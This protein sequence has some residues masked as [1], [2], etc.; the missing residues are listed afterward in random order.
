MA[1]LKGVPIGERGAPT[2]VFGTLAIDRRVLITSART[3]CLSNVAAISIGT[4]PVQTSPAGLIGAIVC[5]LAA[6]GAWY[7]LGTFFG[8]V[9]IAA[10]FVVL[11]LAAIGLLA[12]WFLTPRVT[13]RFLIITSNDGTRSLFAA[14]APELLEKVRRI[15]TDKINGQDDDATFTINFDKGTI[16]PPPPG[17]AVKAEQPAHGAGH[18]AAP[19]SGRGDSHDQSHG[20]PHPTHRDSG[21]EAHASPTGAL[22]AGG[23]GTSAGPSQSTHV[24]Y[25]SVLGQIEQM[26]RFYAQQPQARHVEER[27]SELELLMR[28]GTPTAEGRAR[29]RQLAADLGTILQSYPA[30]VQFFQGIIHLVGH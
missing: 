8:G 7:A 13:A 17:D 15:L 11:V 6:G 24:D 9:A 10:A 3:I 1:G 22:A 2:E 21:Y 14:H 16:D 27:L 4:F 5:A 12:K 19:A 30:M 29:V 20:Q 28:S 23:H 25:S 18:P 26:Q